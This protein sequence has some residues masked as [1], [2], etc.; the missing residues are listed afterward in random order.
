MHE[1]IAI[2]IIFSEKRKFIDTPDSLGDWDS[3]LFLLVEVMII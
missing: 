1:L 2:A 3:V